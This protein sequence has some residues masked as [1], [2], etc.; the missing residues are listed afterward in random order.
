MLIPKIYRLYAPGARFSKYPVW[1]SFFLNPEISH[2]SNRRIWQ[3]GR[4]FLGDKGRNNFWRLRYTRKSLSVI[5][6]TGPKKL[7]NFIRGENGKLSFWES[8]L[9]IHKKFWDF[10]LD[11]LSQKIYGAYDSGAGFSK[12]VVWKSFSLNP[13]NSRILNG[14]FWKI[15]RNFLKNQGRNNF[16][17]QKFTRKSF[18]IIWETGRK[19]LENSIRGGYEKLS[20]WESCLKIHKKFWDFNLDVLSQKIYGAY[21]SG[22]GFSKFVV[23]KSFSLN[24]ENSRIL[25][26]RFWKIGRNFLK[27]QGRNNFWRQKFTRKCLSIIW[28]TGRKKL[29]NS[30][31]G[32]Y[33]KLSF[34]ESCL[35]I[36]K[37]VWDFNLDLLSQKI[38]GA[39]DS[40]AGFSK[41]MVWKS[42]SLNPE[43]S[44]T[45]NGRFWKIGRNF[46]N[47]EG[48]NNFW[49]LKF[50]R[51]SRSVILENVQKKVE[52]FVG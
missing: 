30:I 36:H 21:D 14:R 38:Y 51:R 39:Y 22:A 34:W 32:G 46:L 11:V 35:K 47:N 27:N 45:S 4:N 43:N 1:K 19:N 17:R 40:G 23:W 15:G 33:G 3:I 41:Y 52:N 18:S 16:W 9:K 10:N 7:E 26:G 44:H 28:E 25:N 50:T 13:E 31:R 37:K 5:W 42:F 24:P 20:F 12:F 2:I 48:R 49:R 29:E 6:E 8:C